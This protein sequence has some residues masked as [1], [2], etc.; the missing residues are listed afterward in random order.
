MNNQRVHNIIMKHMVNIKKLCH[1]SGLKRIHASYTIKLKTLVVRDWSGETFAC[2]FFI[3]RSTDHSECPHDLINF[4]FHPG[5]RLSFF[6]CPKESVWI[7]LELENFR[8]VLFALNIV[9]DIII[10]VYKFYLRIDLLVSKWKGL[11]CSSHTNS[12]WLEN[13]THPIKSLHGRKSPGKFKI[14]TRLQ[15]NSMNY[16]TFSFL[17]QPAWVLWAKPYHSKNLHEIRSNYLAIA[18]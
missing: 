8:T 11:R 18:H 10:I 14:H 17:T 9:A 5:T 6:D 1:I 7:N 16:L 15:R 12:V 2:Q 3:V 13:L 4:M